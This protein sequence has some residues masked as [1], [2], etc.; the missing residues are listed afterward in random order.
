MSLENKQ[1]DINAMAAVKRWIG[2]PTITSIVKRMLAG[3]TIYAIGNGGSASQSSHMVG[4]LIGR[5]CD[6]R[7]P[8]KAISLSDYAVNSCISNDFGYDEVFARQ[9]EALLTPKDILIS[10][11]TSGKSKNIRRA[12]EVAF[13]ASALNIAIMGIPS[14]DNDVFY[15]KYCDRILYHAENGSLSSDIQ[16]A[17]EQTLHELC[18]AIE[19]E[20][21][22]NVPTYIYENT[23]VF[24]DLDGTL[25]KH[26]GNESGWTGSEF[27]P[28]ALDTL[29]SWQLHG[30]DIVVTTGRPYYKVKDVIRKLREEGIRI[31]DVVSGLNTGLRYLINDTKQEYIDAG[32]QHKAVAINLVRDHSEWSA[33]RGDV[34][35][36]TCRYD[37]ETEVPFEEDAF[38]PETEV[39]QRIQDF[40]ESAKYK[41]QTIGWLNGCFDCFHDGH[42]YLIEEAKKRCD[43]LLGGINDD[44]SIKRTKGEG[45]PYDKLDKR[46]D[47]VRS[48]FDMDP[49]VFVI[50]KDTPQ[51][52]IEQIKPDI[53]FKGDDYKEED[54]VGHELAK[55]VLIPRLPGLSTTEILKQKEEQ[56]EILRRSISKGC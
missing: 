29:S 22:Y 38:L 30:Y 14:A 42:K 52:L 20:M 1:I 26:E 19:H 51:V 25:V 54:V 28:A 10:F 24:V 4:E 32:I 8:L 44:E 41:G 6:T 18:Y 37:R 9:L 36:Q 17:H 2:D 43:I 3:G 47:N 46:L 55:V 53:I 39:P 33:I 5:L 11:S 16:L 45:R 48:V 7:I 13:K 21:I 34:N 23:S 56:I 50:H 40:I 31:F 49:Y 27:L 15:G 35:N 12:V